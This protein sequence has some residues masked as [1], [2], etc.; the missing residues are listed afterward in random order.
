VAFGIAMLAVDEMHPGQLRDHAKRV[1]AGEARAVVEVQNR[2]EAELAHELEQPAQKQLGALTL[3]AHDHVQAVATGVVEEEHGDAASARGARAKVLAVR[4][5]HHHPMRV[6]EARRQAQPL[7]EA[8]HRAA[9]HV[10]DA[11]AVCLGATHDL[12]HRRRWV[13]ALFLLHERHPLR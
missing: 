4:Q 6:R 8:P 13:R 3:R 9:V 5:H 10:R 2:H 1:I 11:Q 7:A 12:R